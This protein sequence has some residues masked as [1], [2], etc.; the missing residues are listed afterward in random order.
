MFFGCCFFALEPRGKLFSALKGLMKSNDMS[1]DDHLL[2]IGNTW[3]VC[4]YWHTSK[5]EFAYVRD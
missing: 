4:L 2:T 3:E 5:S 1:I